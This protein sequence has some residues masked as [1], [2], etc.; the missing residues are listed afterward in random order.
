MQT[1]IQTMR[2]ARRRLVACDYTIAYACSPSVFS[3]IFESL[4]FMYNV[5][6]WPAALPSKGLPFAKPGC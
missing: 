6:G 3:K 2:G 5:D 1:F 4:R